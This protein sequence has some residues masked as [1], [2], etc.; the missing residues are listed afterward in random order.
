MTMTPTAKQ[1]CQTIVNLR[2]LTK[3]TVTATTR[4]QNDMLRALNSIDLAAVANELPTE[5]R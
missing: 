1:A 2:K 4:A 5:C 3:E